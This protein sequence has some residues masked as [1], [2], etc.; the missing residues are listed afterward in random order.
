MDNDRT[1]GMP[2]PCS[3][4]S[5]VANYTILLE[6]TLIC[7]EMDSSPLLL[8]SLRMQYT[9]SLSGSKTTRFC[10]WLMRERDD[11][12]SRDLGPN[13]LIRKQEIHEIKR[14]MSSRSSRSKA[15]EMWKAKLYRE[16]S[17]AERL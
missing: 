7:D 15:A 5:P 1:T 4:E 9:A 2:V 3:Y 11:H 14:N 8:R 16:K 6:K 17:E 13:A 12:N 10:L